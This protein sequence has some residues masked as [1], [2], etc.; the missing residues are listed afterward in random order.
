ME[1]KKQING[2]F[3]IFTENVYFD[4]KTAKSSIYYL[5]AL[6]FADIKN[7]EV[8]LIDLGRQQG[9]LWDS[10][11]ENQMNSFEKILNRR[12]PSRASKSN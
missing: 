3:N 12:C 5:C 7:N 9:K 8:Y 2:I 11:L 6:G 1:L 10:I 4:E